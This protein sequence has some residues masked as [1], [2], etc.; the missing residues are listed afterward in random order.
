MSVNSTG[1]LKMQFVSYLRFEKAV[2]SDGLQGTCYDWFSLALVYNQIKMR[3]N[4]QI[5]RECYLNSMA[6]HVFNSAFSF[7]PAA[8]TRERG[9]RKFNMEPMSRCFPIL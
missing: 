4:M 1:N 9:S 7:S 5:L 3:R 8:L 6:L 2:H